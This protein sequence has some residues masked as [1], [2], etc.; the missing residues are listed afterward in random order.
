MI[1]SEIALEFVETEDDS[2][3]QLCKCQFCKDAVIYFYRHKRWL[4]ASYHVRNSDHTFHRCHRPTSWSEVAKIP[5]GWEYKRSDADDDKGC[6]I[7]KKYSV[8]EKLKD[9][10]LDRLIAE[11]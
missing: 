6:F 4:G 7:A 5:E 10:N 11:F 9:S 3:S 8:F 2:I 1:K